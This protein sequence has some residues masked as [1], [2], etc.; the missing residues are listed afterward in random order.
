MDHGVGRSRPHW[1]RGLSATLLGVILVAGG[2]IA[3]AMPTAAANGCNQGRKAGPGGHEYQLVC[4]RVTFAQAKAAAVKAGGHLATIAGAQE[5][6]FVFG[7]VDVPGAWSEPNIYDMITG[8]WIGFLQAP[9]GAE[10]AGGWGWVTGESVG[11]TNWAS[12]EPNDFADSPAPEDRAVFWG[13]AGVPSGAWNDIGG[14]GSAA[15]VIEFE[16]K[17]KIDWTMPARL[18]VDTPE[19]Q[20]WAV[21]DGLPGIRDLD[22]SEWKANVFLRRGDAKYTCPAGTRFHWSVKPLDG[23]KVLRKPD[24]GC[25]FSLR[26]SRLGRYEV[27]ATKETRRNGRWQREDDPTARRTVLLKDWLIVGLGDSNGSGEGNPS[28]FYYDRCNRGTASYQFQTALYVEQQDPRTS[29]SFIH[30]SCSGARIEHLVDRSYPGTRAASPP[31]D[32]QIEQVSFLLSQTTPKRSVDAVLVSAGVNDLAFGP[33]LKFCVVEGQQTS[34][35]CPELGTFVDTDSRGQITSIVANANGMALRDRLDRLVNQ[36]PGRYPPLSRAL[37]APIGPSGGLDVAPNR[38]FIT[39]YPDFMHG[40]D[41]DYCDTSGGDDVAIIWG[42]QTWT[43]LSQL[44]ARLDRKVRD[45]AGAYGWR[46]IGTSP[47]FLTRGYCN[48]SNSLFSGV[49]QSFF[50]WNMD[51]PFHPNAEAHLLSRDLHT[52][53]VCARLYKKDDCT[54]TPR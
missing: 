17:P 52:P 3:G 19:E 30:A 35:P 13:P 54:G 47:A 51:G 15:Y 48:K 4:N 24:P 41:G 8:P 21:L 6:G 23:G 39:Q 5:N 46:T 11:F 27:T 14:G 22:P 36:L 28:T 25:S 38:V 12:G 7:L 42:K 43:W 33:V 16:P 29:V 50:R 26:V 9:D 1:L 10:P 45:A 49:V 44:D 32:P 37:K 40:S 2:Q 53:L 31:L 18:T 34:T 20:N